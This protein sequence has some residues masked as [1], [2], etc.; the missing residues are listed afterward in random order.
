MGSFSVEKLYRH[1]HW[2]SYFLC[3][4]AFALLMNIIVISNVIWVGV[5]VHLRE[6]YKFS[7]RTHVNEVYCITF[8]LEFMLKLWACRPG[9]RHRAFLDKWFSLDSFL[10][11]NLVL[12]TLMEGVLSFIQFAKG[13]MLFKILRLLRIS[14][15]MRTARI[16]ENM[17]ELKILMGSM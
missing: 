9:M 15:I 4:H 12:E 14:R 13:A 11:V 16:I 8:S 1:H 6:H 17:P 5:D 7:W 3:S 2:A 10:L